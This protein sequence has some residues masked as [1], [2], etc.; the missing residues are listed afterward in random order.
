M[1]LDIL[2]ITVSKEHDLRSCYYLLLQKYTEA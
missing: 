1:N 2:D